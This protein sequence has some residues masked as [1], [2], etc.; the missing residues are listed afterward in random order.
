[1]YT[2]HNLIVFDAQHFF[3]YHILLTIDRAFIFTDSLSQALY[4]VQTIF[5]R[6]WEASHAHFI[7]I[8]LSVKSKEIWFVF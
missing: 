7:A 3:T 5:D 4:A 6:A 1:M 2:E 8:D